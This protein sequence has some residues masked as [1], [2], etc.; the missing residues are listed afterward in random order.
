MP[1]NMGRPTICWE[2]PV[3]NIF[4]IPQAKLPQDP[5]MTAAVPVIRSKP[6]DMITITA[7]P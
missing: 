6:A 3:V 4:S 2:T 5:R 7:R 1:E